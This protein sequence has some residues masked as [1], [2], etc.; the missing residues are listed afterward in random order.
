ML[1]FWMSMA[2]TGDFKCPVIPCAAKLGGRTLQGVVVLQCP[3]GNKS[4]PQLYQEFLQRFWI[5]R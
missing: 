1:V 2:W 3:W 4:L 5:N